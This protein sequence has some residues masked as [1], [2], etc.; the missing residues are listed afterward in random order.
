MNLKK[1][2]QNPE[3][4]LRNLAFFRIR[5]IQLL[6]APNWHV[7]HGAVRICVSTWTKKGWFT[8]HV[9]WEHLEVEY[10]KF[11]KVPDPELIRNPVLSSDL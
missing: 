1:K 6:G 7:K 9:S 2:L 10:C 4:L 11:E 3:I 5:D 8:L